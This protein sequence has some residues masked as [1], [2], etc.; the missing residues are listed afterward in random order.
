MSSRRR[1]RKTGNVFLQ[2]AI[3]NV[4]RRRH[5]SLNFRRR[6]MKIDPV[7]ARSTGIFAAIALLLVL[8]AFFLVQGYMVHIVMPGVSME[9]TIHANDTIL[10]DRISYKISSP[11]ADDI[12]AFLPSS[13]KN[14][15]ISVKRI[16]G[17]P[18]NSIRIS[19]GYLYVDGEKYDESIDASTMS[20]AGL[21]ADEITLGEDEYFVL[22]DN[23]NN[24]EDSRFSSVGVVNRNDI[25]GKVWFDI[26]LSHWG[27]IH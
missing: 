24:S 2:N 19:N 21:A 22:G 27:V 8:L 15:Q 3:S 18:G 13:N 26:T 5:E 9:E 23:R 16:V 7:K 6:R 14:A 4:K 12:I 11:E 25:V 17:L 1:R 20:D 10:V